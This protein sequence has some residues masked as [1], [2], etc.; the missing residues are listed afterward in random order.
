MKYRIVVGFK[1]YDMYFEFEN[2]S[3]AMYFA[4]QVKESA[5]LNSEGVAKLKYMEFIEKEGVEEDAKNDT[6]DGCPESAD[7]DG[8]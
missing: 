8:T 2:V 4:K 3:D 5:A 6:G 7:A 1:F